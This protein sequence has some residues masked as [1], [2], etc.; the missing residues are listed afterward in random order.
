MVKDNEFGKLWDTERR[1][2]YMRAYA[3]LPDACWKKLKSLYPKDK[4][5]DEDYFKKRY[6]EV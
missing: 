4:R 5:K 1:L 6:G 2:R 3:E